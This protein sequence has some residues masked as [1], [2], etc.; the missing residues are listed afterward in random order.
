MVSWPRKYNLTCVGSTG[1]IS[2]S[3]SQPQRRTLQ[4]DNGRGICGDFRDCWTRDS[5]ARSY[6]AS[7]VGEEAKN[8]WPGLQSRR[9]LK[10]IGYSLIF[11]LF[12]AMWCTWSEQGLVVLGGYSPDNGCMTAERTSVELYRKRVHLRIEK[13]WVAEK[14]NVETSVG[15]EWRQGQSNCELQSLQNRP[16]KGWKQTVYC[17]GF[18]S[19][20]TSGDTTE[21]P[22]RLR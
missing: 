14:L 16:G 8:K 18:S 11:F 2:T 5:L 13:K 21:E 17:I 19:N 12:F 6:F 22:G 4:G 9:S 20:H 3:E 7:V 10:K 15:C 1:P